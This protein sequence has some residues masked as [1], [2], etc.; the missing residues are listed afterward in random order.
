MVIHNEIEMK[1]NCDK[2][3]RDEKKVKRHGE[4]IWGE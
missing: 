1:R 3:R 4:N 2:G